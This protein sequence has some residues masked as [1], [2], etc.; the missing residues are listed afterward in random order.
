IQRELLPN[1]GS[2]R[3]GGVESCGVRSGV[4]D[5][6]LARRQSLAHQV[7]LDRLA[8][9]HDACDQ[10][11]AVEPPAHRSHGEAHPAI[12]DQGRPSAEPRRDARERPPATLVGVHDLDA[13]AAQ[14]AGE[15][16]GPDRICRPAEEIEVSESSGRR[17]GAPP[18]TRSGQDEDAVTT[19]GEAAGEI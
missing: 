7:V 1:A 5:V 3:P 14:D 11:A 13:L 12:D 4:Y 10:T 15:A 8:D 9:R 19:R 2:A 17:F 18:L 16:R 6:D